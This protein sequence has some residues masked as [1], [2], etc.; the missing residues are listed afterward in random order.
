M[1]QFLKDLMKRFGDLIIKLIS[2]KG[3]FAIGMT[4]LVIVTGEGLWYAFAA[5]GI[6]IGGR[7]LAKARDAL[8]TLK[9]PVAEEGK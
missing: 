7:E 2:V 1:K 8:S 3:L 4:V 5:W 6:L 9:A